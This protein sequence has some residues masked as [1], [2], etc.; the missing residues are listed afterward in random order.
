MRGLELRRGARPGGH[1]P[2]P[3]FGSEVSGPRKGMG[4]QGGR[5]THKERGGQ[6]MEPKKG[7]SEGLVRE[8]ER[9]EGARRS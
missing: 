3:L 9:R 4:L 7:V 5:K 8:G 6:G 2:E 1:S